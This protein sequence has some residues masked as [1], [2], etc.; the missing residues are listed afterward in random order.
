MK[1]GNVSTEKAGEDLKQF[2]SDLNQ[3][4]TENQKYRKKYQSDAIT[5]I[6]YLCNSRQNVIDLFN[7]Y[8]K[9]R[10]KAMLK[11]KQGTGQD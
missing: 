5:N 11:T 3:T 4:N 2:I 10:S 6:K 9:I 8:A 1:N 7:D